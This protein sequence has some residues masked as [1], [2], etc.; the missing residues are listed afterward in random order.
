MKK[1]LAALV[2][3]L[4]TAALA[5][6]DVNSQQEQKKSEG[7]ITTGIDANEVLPSASGSKAQKEKKQEEAAVMNKTHAFNLSGDLKSSKKNEVTLSRQKE[8]LPDAELAVRDQTLVLLDGKTATVADI[9]EGSQV[10]AR[11]QID[12]KDTVAVELN[13]TTPQGVAGGAKKGTKGTKETKPAPAP[14]GEKGTTPAPTQGTQQGTPSTQ[15][16]PQ[17]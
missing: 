10:R 16:T 7:R 14:T 13:A 12:G 11:F 8:G 6:S 5:Q 1:L 17:Q 15:P 3:T 9:P 2:I 4:S